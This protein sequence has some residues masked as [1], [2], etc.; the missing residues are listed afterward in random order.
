MVQSF[1]QPGGNITGVS[2][3]SAELA[4]KRI[5]LLKD[6]VPGLRRIGLYDPRAPGKDKE[7]AAPAD[8]TE[9]D[10]HRDANGVQ[11]VQKL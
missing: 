11:V 5:G 7:L 1:A 6:A 8:K 4:V 9:L 2:C 10:T 3:Q